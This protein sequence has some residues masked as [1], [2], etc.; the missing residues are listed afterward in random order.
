MTTQN[1]TQ[2]GLALI[3]DWIVAGREAEQAQKRY[4]EANK[5]LGEAEEAL[6]AWL[7]PA[8][9]KPQP[10]EKICIWAGDSLFQLE[11]GG[12]TAKNPGFGMDIETRDRITV[13]YRGAKFEELAL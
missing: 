5:R 9:I 13:R 10:G 12:V 2:E 3:R 8:V 4:Y 6:A 7:R 11:V 1:V